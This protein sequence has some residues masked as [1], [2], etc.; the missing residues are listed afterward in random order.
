MKVARVRQRRRGLKG[1]R[2]AV[3]ARTAALQPSN[4]SAAWVT[5]AR[6]DFVY[7][8]WNL[9]HETVAT[10][11]ANATTNVSEIEYFWGPDLSGTLQGAGGVGGLLA[12]SM[13]GCFYFPA[14]DNNGNIVKY[15]DETGTVVAAY[16]YDDFGA[17]LSS[18]GPLAN[19]FRFRFSTKYFDIETELCYYGYRFYCLPI[20]QWISRDPLEE[21]GGSN[22]YRSSSR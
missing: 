9:I 19:D 5:C 4:A 10:V 6:R 2:A 15:V 14:Y 20:S 12:V 1:V 18:T 22:L 7:D 13:E 21:Y 17:T 11:D 16:G 8:D 3:A